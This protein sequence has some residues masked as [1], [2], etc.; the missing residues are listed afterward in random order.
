[1]TRDEVL[2][3]IEEARSAIQNFKDQ[4][5]E[6]AF[7]AAELEKVHKIRNSSAR[8]IVEARTIGAAGLQCPSC[9]GS[10]RV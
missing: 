3:K 8:L 6:K 1:M 10:G 2:R 7:S 4:D 9:G 5:L